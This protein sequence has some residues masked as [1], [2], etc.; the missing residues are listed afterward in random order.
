MIKN[1][2]AQR[3]FTRG[4]FNQ[5]LSQGSIFNTIS[6]PLLIIVLRA[7]NMSFKCLAQY[8][9]E[10]LTLNWKPASARPFFFFFLGFGVL[11]KKKK[12]KKSGSSLFFL[13]PYIIWPSSS[14]SSSSGWRAATKT[15]KEG[16]GGRRRVMDGQTDRQTDRQTAGNGERKRISHRLAGYLF[17]R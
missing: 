14:S 2:K 8:N 16:G 5:S 1:S 12:K 6:Q 7:I 4:T 15:V 13:Y 17:L 3:R 9:R 10:V 11:W